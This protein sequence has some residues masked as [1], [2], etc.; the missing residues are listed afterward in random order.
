MSDKSKKKLPPEFAARA[1]R[2]TAAYETFLQ[3]LGV[4]KKERKTLAE[5]V[6]HRI[7]TSKIDELKKRIQKL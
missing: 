3:E 1:K 5:R 2:V 4:L 7:E 6:L